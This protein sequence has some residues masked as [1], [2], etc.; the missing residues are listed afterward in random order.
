MSDNQKKTIFLGLAAAGV[1]L[2]AYLAYSY[3][4]KSSEPTSMQAKLEKAKLMVEV[5]RAKDGKQIENQYFL[6]LLQFVGAET[7]LRT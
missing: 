4:T 6:S 5:K 3:W 1:A 2:G 7:R